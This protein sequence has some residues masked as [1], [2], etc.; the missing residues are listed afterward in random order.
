[1]IRELVFVIIQGNFTKKLGINSQ[2][3]GR[4]EMREIPEVQKQVFMDSTEYQQKM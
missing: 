4:S 1:M 3:L 2:T